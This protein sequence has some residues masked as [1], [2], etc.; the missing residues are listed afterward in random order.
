MILKC[1]APRHG[2]RFRLCG[3]LIGAV[4]DGSQVTRV[5][6]D[7][8]DVAPGSFG[9]RCAK[10]QRVFEVAPPLDIAA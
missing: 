3:G 8:N 7:L 4:P 1:Q 5:V 2:V 10:C 9:M 6:S